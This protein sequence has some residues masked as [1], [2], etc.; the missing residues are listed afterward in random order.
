MVA[1]QGGLLHATTGAGKTY[2]VALGALLLAQALGVPLQ[3]SG[4]QADAL[5]DELRR[6]WSYRALPR[7]AFQWALD[8]VV[9]DR[10]SVV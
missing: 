3:G 8:F 9:Q 10:K 4:F 1:G 6:A 7:E 5:F 2:A